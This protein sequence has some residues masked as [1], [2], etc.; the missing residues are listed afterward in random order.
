MRGNSRKIVIL[1]DRDVRL[2]REIAVMR[3]IDREQAKIVAGFGS[4]TRA[5]ARLLGLTEAGYLRR[6][7]WGSVG[8]A[9]KAIYALAPRGAEIAGAPERGPRRKRDQILAADFFSMHQLSVNGVYCTLKFMGLPDGVTFVRWISFGEP[10]EG[11][12][13]TPDGFAVVE[14]F[15][16]SSALFIEVDLGT[17]NRKAWQTKVG[18]YLAYA[19]SG[20]FARNFG[21]GQFRTLVIVPSESRITSLRSAT[22]ELTDKIF[23]FTTFARIGSDGF[24]AAIW[25]KP[26]GG[27]RHPLP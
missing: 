10:I 5:N 18:A 11:T 13:L 17:E 24:W 9:R 22:A 1:Q 19:T 27:E 20:N 21:A 12:H 16:K 7:F 14:F 26:T 4:T 23:R 6:F 3:V 2:I 25:Q 15:G 8:G